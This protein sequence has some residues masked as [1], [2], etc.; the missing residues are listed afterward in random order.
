MRTESVRPL[1]TIGSLIPSTPQTRLA[2]VTLFAVLLIPV[3]LGSLRGVGHVLSCRNQVATPFA[4]LLEPGES[5]VV[6]GAVSSGSLVVAEH[7]GS[8]TVDIRADR[9]DQNRLGLV[10]SVANGSKNPWRG[11]VQLDVSGV[12]IPVPIGRVEPGITR[13]EPVVLT[14]PSGQ[15]EL[16]GALLVGP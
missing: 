16:T 9:P 3:G 6:T 12:R 14:L 1:G 2:F 4:V 5:P 8:L 10:I 13:E 11:T 15:T 7:C